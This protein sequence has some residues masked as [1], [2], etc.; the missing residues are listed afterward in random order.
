MIRVIK[1]DITFECESEDD[2][3]LAL[4]VLTETTEFPKLELLQPVP[5]GNVDVALGGYHGQGGQGDVTTL[6]TP[7]SWRVGGP[8]Q[9]AFGDDETESDDSESP[10]VAHI[11]VS[12][13]ESEILEAVMLF[14]EGVTVGSLAQLLGMTRKQVGGRVQMLK[15]KNLVEKMQGHHTWRATTFARRA[16]VVAG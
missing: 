9:S 1:G 7:P 4:G 5:V 3:R 2:L 13:L 14:S 6:P 10:T 11:S 12:K 16:K 15:R 8:P